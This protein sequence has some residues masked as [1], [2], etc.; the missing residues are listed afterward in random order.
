VFAAGDLDGDHR[1]TFTE[2]YEAML[3][4]WCDYAPPLPPPSRAVFRRLFERADRDGSDHLRADELRI[5]V[6]DLLARYSFRFAA[7]KLLNYVVAPVLAW[8]LVRTLAEGS[9]RELFAAAHW[10]T[11][12][13]RW[14]PFAPRS[15]VESMTNGDFWKEA[16][17]VLLVGTLGDYVVACGGTVYDALRARKEEAAPGE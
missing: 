3:L 13:A 7:H 6:K 1:L 5:L 9:L 14:L 12:F 15:F 8:G 16:F 10:K 4:V 2:A 17:T 11:W